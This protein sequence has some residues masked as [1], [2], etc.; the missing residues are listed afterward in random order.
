[1]Y[2]LLL[3]AVLIFGSLVTHAKEA[4]NVG[5]GNFPPFFVEDTQ[6]GL[7]MDITKA[8]FSELPEYEVNFVFMSNSRLVYEINKGERLDV[9]CNVFPQSNVDAYLSSPVFRYTDVA[10]S[11]KSKNLTIQSTDDLKPLSIATY[12]G[13][14]DLHAGEFKPMAL[15][16]PQYLEYSQPKE[17]T[18]ALLAGEKDVRVGDIHIFHYDIHNPVYQKSN[19]VSL[20][21]FAIHYLWPNVYGHMA[22]KDEKLRNRVN[23]VINKLNGNGTLE[24]IYNNFQVAHPINY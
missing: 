12:Q 21:D 2:R 20:D 15:K 1:M 11:L 9:A 8:I 13:A 23:E 4:L 14:M 5:V 19:A 16:N 6:S 24:K 17:T 22:F 18:Q 7:F 10:V 3:S